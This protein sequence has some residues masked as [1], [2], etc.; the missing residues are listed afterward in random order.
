MSEEQVIVQQNEVNEAL[1]QVD[2]TV[3]DNNEQQH[4]E[5]PN[6]DTPEAREESKDFIINIDSNKKN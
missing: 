5:K 2:P 1:A 6:I 4:Q 3:K